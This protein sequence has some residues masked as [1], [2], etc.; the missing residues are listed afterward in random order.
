M[1][2]ACSVRI[3]EYIEAVVPHL[4]DLIVD[5]PKELLAGSDTIV[6]GNGNPEFAELVAGVEP[7]LDLSPFSLERFPSWRGA[8]RG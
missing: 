8:R 5:D 4:A 6:V 1:S 3:R 2:R 7:T